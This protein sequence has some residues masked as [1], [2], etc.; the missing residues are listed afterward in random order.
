MSA[1]ELAET[2]VC[3]ER[4]FKDHLSKVLGVDSPGKKSRGRDGG[5]GALCLDILQR[6]LWKASENIPARKLHQGKV[7]A[8]IE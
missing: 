4:T 5:G 1:Q 6:A 8:S 7:L 2:S 3:T